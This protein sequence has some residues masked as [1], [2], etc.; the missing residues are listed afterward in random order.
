M[1]TD[2]DRLQNPF[3]RNA[4]AHW[5]NV[6]SIPGPKSKKASASGAP[7]RPDVPEGFLSRRHRSVH[8]DPALLKRLQ[9]AVA[10]GN[11]DGE[12]SIQSLT[13]A[14]IRFCPKR[15]GRTFSSSPRRCWFR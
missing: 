14:Q 13:D 3:F 10:E 12:L 5:P 4:A 7:G 2:S 9:A 8:K 6:I 15:F 11:L 1:I